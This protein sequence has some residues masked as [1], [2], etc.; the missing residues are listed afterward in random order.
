MVI[1]FIRLMPIDCYYQIDNEKH[2]FV[3]LDRSDAAKQLAIE[4][5]NDG[6]GIYSLTEWCNIS[7]RFDDL[8]D[9]SSDSEFESDNIPK[10]TFKKRGCSIL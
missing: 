1:K 5:H 4:S 10:N 8:S 7:E 2:D 6:N 3:L 9:S